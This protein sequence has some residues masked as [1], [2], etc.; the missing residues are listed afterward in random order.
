MALARQLS[1]R[2]LLTNIWLIEDAAAREDV[3]GALNQYDIALR[4]SRMAPS[5]LFPVLDRALADERLIVPIGEKLSSGQPWVPTFVEYVAKEGKQPRPLAQALL[6]RP[7]SLSRLPDSLK[8]ALLNKLVDSGSLDIAEK[9]YAGLSGT[10]AAR[11]AQS[12]IRNASFEPGGKWPP[13][14]WSLIVSPDYGA[15]IA[16][17]DQG[18]AIFAA[19]EASGTVAKQLIGLRPGRYELQ[20]DALIQA[21]AG[22]TALWTISCAN[23]GAAPVSTL[24]LAAGGDN[25]KRSA[26]QFIVPGTGCDRQWIR[27]DVTAGSD[28]E[29]LNGTISRAQVVP[30]R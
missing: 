15:D 18:L 1:R 22:G 27:L 29:G 25:S 10:S 16:G 5:I 12:S 13:F 19:N 11:P 8:S 23:Q 14:D 17:R 2:D 3:A 21:A 26:S 6:S 20:S 30:R 4:T 7:D 24:A 28:A 9:F